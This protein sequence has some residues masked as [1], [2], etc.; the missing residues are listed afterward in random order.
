MIQKWSNFGVRIG[1]NSKIM[2]L[3]REIIS[4]IEKHKLCAF[5]DL[6]FPSLTWNGNKTIPYLDKL[7]V[8]SPCLSQ[9]AAFYLNH[10]FTIVTAVAVSGSMCKKCLF[11]FPSIFAAKFFFLFFLGF[12][13]LC[14]SEKLIH[15]ISKTSSLGLLSKVGNLSVV[16]NQVS[17]A[18]TNW[19]LI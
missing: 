2:Q 1:Q 12:F 5:L 6:F 11:L 9:H 14:S 19:Q 8:F 4:N 18:C 10:C 7:S 16:A 3:I 17:A 15:L 13:L